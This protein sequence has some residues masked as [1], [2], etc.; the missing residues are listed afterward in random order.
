MDGK[1]SQCLDALSGLRWL[2]FVNLNHECI[3]A[4]PSHRASGGGTSDDDLVG[5]IRALAEAAGLGH[6][7]MRTEWES[8]LPN[9]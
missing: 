2:Y 4:I 8:G 3:I 6:A 5:A 7:V 1:A 9:K